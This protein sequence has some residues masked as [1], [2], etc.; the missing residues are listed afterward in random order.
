MT[1][2][3]KSAGPRPVG[4]NS[5]RIH[6][7]EQTFNFSHKLHSVAKSLIL[8]GPQWNSSVG[9]YSH[10]TNLSH[11]GLLF[12]FV[13]PAYFLAFIGTI[14]PISL[15]VTVYGLNCTTFSHCLYDLIFLLWLLWYVHYCSFQCELEVDR[16]EL[17][18][19]DKRVCLFS[20]INYFLQF[21]GQ[22]SRFTYLGIYYFDVDFQF[23]T[24]N[25][26][27]K[28]FNFWKRGW[29]WPLKINPLV[30]PIFK[31]V[32]GNNTE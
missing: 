32:A 19:S 23:K 22:W 16:S 31:W 25:F 11:A 24:C 15:S 14:V 12:S 28:I 9:L 8:F 7:L 1:A 10:K 26:Y 3:Q 2:W 21:A 6:K 27:L 29:G 5:L 13:R 30:S 18:V 17:I 20:F 4:S